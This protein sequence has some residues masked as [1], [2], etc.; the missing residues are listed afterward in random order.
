MIL[1]NLANLYKDKKQVKKAEEAYLQAL[2]MYLALNEKKSSLY[3]PHVASTLNNIANLYGFQSEIALCFVN[4]TV[5]R[6]ASIQFL[7]IFVSLR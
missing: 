3:L 6:H 4:C 1:N 5:N 2:A 7:V